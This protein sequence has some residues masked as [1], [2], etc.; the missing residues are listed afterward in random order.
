MAA[1][2]ETKTIGDREYSVTQWPAEKAIL[3]QARLLKAFGGCISGLFSINEG[4]LSDGIS[5]AFSGLFEKADPEN[6]MKLIK[7]VVVGCRVKSD[8]DSNFSELTSSK[9]T[10]IFTGDG[11]GDVFEVAIFVCVVNYAD[12]FKRPWAEG[13][14][15]LAEK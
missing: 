2:T 5:N 3:M 13:L 12:L 1:K 8:G 7:D 14:R 6:L 4:S 11:L 9:F 10:E 15:A